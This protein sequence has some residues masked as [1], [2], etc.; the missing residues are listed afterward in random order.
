LAEPHPA[1]AYRIEPGKPIDWATQDASSAVDQSNRG[2][3][4]NRRLKV[5]SI[6]AALLLLVLTLGCGARSAQSDQNGNPAAP[7]GS[8]SA[9]DILAKALATNP[10]T[11]SAKATFEANVTF[12]TDPAKPESTDT[13]RGNRGAD[14]RQVPSFP[15][16]M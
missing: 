10:S 4:V 13:P 3:T 15:G 12:D 8:L 9:S 2:V 7:A 1:E 6:I 14:R 5:V 11:K 16:R